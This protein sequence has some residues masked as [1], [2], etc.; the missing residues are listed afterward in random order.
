MQKKLENTMQ[1][2][3]VET[4]EVE[5]PADKPVVVLETYNFPA[6]GLAIRASSLQQA[7]KELSVLINK[8]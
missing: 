7:E 5:A 3:D 1:T 2:A 4:V 8:K 6:Y